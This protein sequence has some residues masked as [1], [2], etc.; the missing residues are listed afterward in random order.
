MKGRLL[1]AMGDIIEGD[2]QLK[3]AMELRREIVPHDHR[4]VDQLKNQDFDEL[5]WYY[6]R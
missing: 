5:V 1:K 6:S 3:R 4:T 2:A